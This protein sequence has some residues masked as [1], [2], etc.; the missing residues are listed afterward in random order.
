MFV[1]ATPVWAKRQELNT[2]LVFLSKVGSLLS[3]V[4]H[5][6]A[7]NF[8]RL[9]VNGKFVSFGPARTVY[10]Y[11]RVDEISL[12]GL[13][14]KAENEIKIEVAG[15]NCRSL[16]TCIQPSF[17][18][19]ELFEAGK[20]VLYTGKDFDCFVNEQKL[21]KVMRYSAQRHFSE[22][23]DLSC[24]VLGKKIE[25]FPIEKSPKFIDRI[26]TYP[27]YEVKDASLFGKGKFVTDETIPFH[28]RYS[29]ENTL[30]YW[31]AFPDS[32]V[33]SKPRY[34]AEKQRFLDCDKANLPLL[35]N[36]GEYALFDF[37]KVETGFFSLCAVAQEDC[38]IV[39]AWTELGN[40]SS[41][42][43]TDM[44]AR[45]VIEYFVPKGEKLDFFSF[46][47]YTAKKIAV[48]LKSG[49]ATVEKVSVRTFE[50]DASGL[51]DHK[52][53]DPTLKA[54][55]DAGVRTFVQN[56]LDIFMDCPSR[57]RAGWQCDSFFTG[58]TEHF[59]F[60][61]V[62]TED[63]Y[64]Q[65]Y[66][67][68]SNHE[69]L[70]PDGVLPMTCPSDIQMVN[71]NG[72][73]IPQWAMWYVIETYEYLT[74]RNKAMD[75][76]LFRESIFK[77]TAY[78]EKF[79]NELGLLEKLESWNFVEW[80]DANKWTHDVNFPTNFLYAHLLTCVGKLYDMPS[81]TVKADKIRATARKLS[82][83]GEVFIDNAVRNDKGELIRTNNCSEACQYY[84]LLFGGVSIDDEKYAFLKEQVHTNFLSFDK[85]HRNF[86]PVNAFIGLYLR[87]V[88]LM[89]Y[90]DGELLKNDLVYFFG[91]MVEETSTLWEYRQRGVGSQDHGFAS[92]ACIAVVK[93]EELLA[94]N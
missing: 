10:G 81:L 24:P 70:L 73:F 26:A 85:K 21:Q 7:V 83:D 80:S 31:G 78:L 86:T 94:K 20:S 90:G 60:G 53:S 68:F 5:V 35:V 2:N 67:L 50:R 76:E 71:G 69:K 52:V 43:F 77:F 4:I 89:D 49:S 15:Y 57:E 14:D 36:E 61:K 16:S 41:F 84:A 92:L 62:P 47:P 8:Y 44:N 63:A 79:E 6:T 38:D 18:C 88:F 51:I 29:F 75:K 3:P 65:N 42:A 93:A 27:R 59:L 64:L 12:A 19:C 9:F 33:V 11:A 32:E 55:Y 28:S 17:L 91:G 13:L 37:G 46:E 22:V 72:R 45:N 25:V 34:W 66:R 87:L 58:R 40:P 30:D 74:Y 48:T 54:I 56:A 82:F 39:L 23:Y 1:N